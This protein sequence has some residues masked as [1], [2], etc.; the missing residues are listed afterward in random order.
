M[1]PST[2]VSAFGAA[3]I[4]IKPLGDRCIFCNQLLEVANTEEYGESDFRIYWTQKLCSKCGWWTL[5]YRGNDLDPGQIPLFHHGYAFG[6]L[7]RFPVSSVEIPLIELREYLLKYYDAR[8]DIHPRK[9]EEIVADIFR[10]YGH[11]VELTAY[12]KDGGIGLFLLSGTDEPTA[13]QIKRNKES[14]KIGV[15]EVDQFLGALLRSKLHNGIFVTTSS[16]TKGAR[17]G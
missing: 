16:Y 3:A 10:N 8:F 5:E 7:E 17:K 1:D 12:S 14:R 6:V 11:R 15:E 2:E 4:S 13:V 9:L